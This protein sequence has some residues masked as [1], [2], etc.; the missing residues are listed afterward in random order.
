MAWAG[1]KKQSGGKAFV[2]CGEALRLYFK[3]KWK[4]RR[5]SERE[6]DMLRLTSSQECSSC[7]VDDHLEGGQCDREDRAYDC[8]PDELLE[9]WTRVRALEKGASV[10]RYSRG[11]TA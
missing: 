10:K 3:W 7:H 1:A 5:C 6:S 2:G 8:K 9:T 4:N 11:R